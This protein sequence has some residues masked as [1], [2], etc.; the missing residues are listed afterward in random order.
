[1]R[2]YRCKACGKRFNALTGTPLARLRHNERWLEFSPSRTDGDTVR[3]SAGRGAVAV[4]TAC[5]W[6]HRVLQTFKTATVRLRG[7]VEADEAVVLD[8]RKGARQ[9]DRAAR[10]RGG[11]AT[12]RG[13]SREP[14]PIRV[15]TDRS[16]TTLRAVLPEVSAHAL[17]VVR[18][19]ALDKDARR[20]TAGAAVDPR[21]AAD[22]GIRHEALNHSAGE[23]VRG[24]L[25]IQTVNNCHPRIKAFL[26][27]FRGIATKDLP[28]YLRCF[29]DVGL[30]LHPSSRTGLNAALGLQPTV[31]VSS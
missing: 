8:S 31:L 4:G 22:L 1:L 19:P 28:N 14:G 11:K 7:I 9:L 6:R 2:R 26:A 17:Q 21:C 10:T 18:D 27:P 29:Q 12:N 13:L 5:R 15:A 25:H 16:G 20:V 23:R 24:D 3:A 30:A